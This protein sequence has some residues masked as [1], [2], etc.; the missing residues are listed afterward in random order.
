MERAKRVKQTGIVVC[1]YN[2]KDYVERCVQSIFDSHATDYDVI[3]VD[4]ASTDG[5]VEM[6]KNV[7]GER[8]TLL[9][10]EENLGG[11]GGFNTGLRY[12]LEQDYE[13]LMCVDN[14][15][16]F[17]ADAIP[18]LK[19]F[20]E[21]HPDVGVA[22]SAICKMDEPDRLQC[23]GFSL[24]W[25]RY[26][27]KE[28]YG[29]DLYD[30][31]LPEIVYA[32]M[33]PACSI[34]MRTQDVRTVGIMR[35]EYFIYW[36]D[37]DWCLRFKAAGLKTAAIRASRVWHKRA[38]TTMTTNFQRYYSRRNKLDMFLRHV[39][40]E[41]REVL[42]RYALEEVYNAASAVAIKGDEA[43]LKTIM[44]A[45]DDAVH[46]VSGKAPEYKMPP[47]QED[48]RLRDL[49]KDVQEIRFLFNGDYFA[50]GK[51][52][53]KIRKVNPEVQVTIDVSRCPEERDKLTVQHPTCRVVDGRQHTTDTSGSGAEQQAL[54]L[55]MCP[56]IF[57]VEDAER[58]GV[59]IDA[60]T[61]LLITEDEFFMA[62]GQ[63]AGREMFVRMWTD[64]LEC[65]C[66]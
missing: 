52:L 17:E 20:L 47:L 54:L 22:G 11:S 37:G 26:G 28:L 49:V 36:D 51:N 55:N 14:D 33:V 4:N 25:D 30:G 59:Y 23:M 5:T 65:T 6:L 34:M 38:A 8:I 53:E 48:V 43:M 60:W 29:G 41:K 46:H 9:C 61:N 16:T 24:D 50:L 1:T 44:Y 31:D 12:A 62:R 3:V 15:V 57:A 21:A 40:E 10:N 7:F 45:F 2:K 66:G 19:A 32:D 56:H 63:R 39:P 64:L 27:T 35:E 18:V 42:V 58:N 13:Y